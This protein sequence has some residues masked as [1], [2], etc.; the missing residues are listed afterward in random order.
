LVNSL[1]AEPAIWE[2]EVGNMT[3][4]AGRELRGNREALFWRGIGLVE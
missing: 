2:N 1:T 3:S 4:G